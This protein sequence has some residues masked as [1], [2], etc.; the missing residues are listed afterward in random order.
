MLVGDSELHVQWLQLGV[1]WQQ[2]RKAV[3]I[4]VASSYGS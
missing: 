3:S 2:L 1:V 4:G